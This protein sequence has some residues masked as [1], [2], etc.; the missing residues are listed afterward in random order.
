MSSNGI[1]TP[2][3]SDHEEEK[4]PDSPVRRSGRKRTPPKSKG[5]D[6]LEVSIESLGEFV[7][8]VFAL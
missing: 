5:F 8:Q 2:Q 3:V 4:M 7:R 6:A 1:H